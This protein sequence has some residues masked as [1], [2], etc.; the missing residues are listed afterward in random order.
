MKGDRIKKLNAIYDPIYR[1]FGEN[2]ARAK[3]ISECQVL[4]KRVTIK[5]VEI[6]WNETD[7]L[8]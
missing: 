7:S 3:P 6:Y 2:K 8:S 1:M 5:E 4:G